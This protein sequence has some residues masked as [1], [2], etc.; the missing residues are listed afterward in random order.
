[1][2]DLLTTG[3]LQIRSEERLSANICLTKECDLELFDGQ[4]SNL[5]V[6]T[7]KR[8][9]AVQNAISDNDSS[10]TILLDALWT[11]EREISNQNSKSPIERCIF[12][13]ISA[14][15]N[16]RNVQDPD[17]SN[18]KN[19]YGLQL[20][21]FADIQLSADL[22]CSLNARSIYSEEYKRQQSPTVSSANSSFDKNRIKCRL[23]EVR[24]TA[25][26]LHAF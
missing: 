9:T 15:L 17:F 18:N 7:P 26:V 13:Y 19:S 8:Q 23:P 3:I 22:L 5:K 14:V 16:S 25:A 4:S 12:S 24:F 21:S 10:I 2:I 11:T 6:A 20:E 1:M